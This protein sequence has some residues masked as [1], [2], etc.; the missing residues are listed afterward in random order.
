LAGPAHWLLLS[1][2]LF[3][4]ACGS[5]TA[6]YPFED[7]QGRQC[8]YECSDS[9]TLTCAAK[10]VAM[11]TAA[12]LEHACLF[13]LP[14][15]LRDAPRVISLCDGCCEPSGAWSSVDPN[16]CVPLVCKSDADCPNQGSRCAAGQCVE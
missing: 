16:D 15:G 7:A 2:C 3:A 9:C 4:L 10:P 13:I 1:C 6:T 14:I 12:N 5:E 11:C 8:K